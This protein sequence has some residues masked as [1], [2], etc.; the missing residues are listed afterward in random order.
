[1]TAIFQTIPTF[2]LFC[3]YRTAWAGLE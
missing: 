2:D 1:L 3:K